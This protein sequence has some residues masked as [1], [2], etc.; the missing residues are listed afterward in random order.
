M[1]LALA[2]RY[3]MILLDKYVEFLRVHQNQTSGTIALRRF[4]VE[5]IVTVQLE[6]AENVDFRVA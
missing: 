3:I 5:K 1:T 2:R 4:Y 6:S